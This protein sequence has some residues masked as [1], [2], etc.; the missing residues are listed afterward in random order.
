MSTNGSSDMFMGNIKNDPQL[1]LPS[2]ISML[3]CAPSEKHM[4]F[5]IGILIPGRHTIFQQKY[6]NFKHEM[7]ISCEGLS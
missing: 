7:D 6:A 5:L 4:L 2:L 3:F 1:L